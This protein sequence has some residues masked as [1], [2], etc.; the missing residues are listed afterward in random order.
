M[1]N[2]EAASVPTRTV[3]D[4][5]VGGMTCA[6]CVARVER[7]LRKVPGVQEV[8]VNLA[9]ESAHIT[10]A[11]PAEAAADSAAD[12][13]QRL[14]RVVRNAGYEP[15][16]H[17]AM[18]PAQAEPGPWAGFAPVALGLA[19]RPLT[20]IDETRYL[21]VAWEMYQSGNWL[22]PTKNFAVYSDKPPML[23]WLVNL[24]WL[25]TG[26]SEFAARMVG[27]VLGCVALWLTSVLGRRLWPDIL[28]EVKKRRRFTWILLSQNAQVVDVRNDVLTLGLAIGYSHSDM[29]KQ[30]NQVGLYEPWQALG[31]NDWR[32][33]VPAGA[34]YSDGIKAL[35]ARLQ[36]PEAP[37]H[38]SRPPCAT[39]PSA[40]GPL[41]RK[42]WPTC[43]PLR[44][45][46]WA[47][48][49]RRPGTGPISPS[50]SRKR[51]MPS[52]SKS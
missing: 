45:S 1:T 20:P 31:G 3:L 50:S 21:A 41:P 16:L 44:P 10:Y 46:S 38:A 33:G 12:M 4:V 7:A 30:E 15:R 25:V 5:G 6:S 8:A 13:A 43:A 34:F 26:V 14:Q 37:R 23:F 2:D 52:A 35:L 48:R 29:P 42:T 39:W 19:L 9:T 22:V 47:C 17:S 40:P 11:L 51:A 49:I 36:A 27:P 28:D 32:P 18:A 24:V